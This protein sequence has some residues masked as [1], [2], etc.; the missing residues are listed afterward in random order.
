MS[1][2]SRLSDGIV[3]YVG[4]FSDQS[5]VYIHDEGAKG[6]GKSVRRVE[7]TM[8]C[9]KARLWPCT[10]AFVRLPSVF[11]RNSTRVAS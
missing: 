4:Y 11:V 9:D 3:I 5:G 8:I 1:R 2:G 6:G 10:T 7:E